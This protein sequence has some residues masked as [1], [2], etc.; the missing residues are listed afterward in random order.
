MVLDWRRTASIVAFV[1]AL[2]TIAAVDEASWVLAGSIVVDGVS[3]RVRDVFVFASSRR[4]AILF[5][6]KQSLRLQKAKV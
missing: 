6:L 2:V 1:A 3:M 5:S 4:K